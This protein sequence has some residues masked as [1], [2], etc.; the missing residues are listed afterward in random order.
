MLQNACILRDSRALVFPHFPP[1]SP[2]LLNHF[3]CA[4]AVKCDTDPQNAFAAQVEILM[5]PHVISSVCLCVC[6][7]VR[8]V[9]TYN[10]KFFDFDCPNRACLFGG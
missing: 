8:M 9:A 7:R 10:L 4:G 1:E 2:Q 5:K 3:L 6:V